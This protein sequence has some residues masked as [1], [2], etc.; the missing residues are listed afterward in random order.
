MEAAGF[1]QPPVLTFT[2]QQGGSGWM[3]GEVSSQKGR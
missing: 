1:A 2:L 3:I